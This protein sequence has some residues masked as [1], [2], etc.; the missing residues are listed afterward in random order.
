MFNVSI[1]NWVY[2]PA[3][4]NIAF[5][6][7]MSTL[8]NNA[9]IFL[10]CYE[11]ET[12]IYWFNHIFHIG[13]LVGWFYDD[14]RHFQQYFSYI[15]R[16]SFIGGENHR[17]TVDNWQAHLAWAGLELIIQYWGINHDIIRDSDTYFHNTCINWI[18]QTLAQFHV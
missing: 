11:K 1:Y 2:F 12:L 13:W 15:M 8:S 14:Y 7:I 17:P 3:S 5:F 18:Q 9:C 6:T 16:I 10:K 4:N